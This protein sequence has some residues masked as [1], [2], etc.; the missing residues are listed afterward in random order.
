ME[1][2]RTKIVSEQEV[3]RWFEEGR[4]YQW[5]TD[6]YRRKYNIET[7]VSMWSNFRHR[8]GLPRRIA[9]NDDL[10]P[11]AVSEKH[12]WAYPATMLRLEAR[13]REGMELSDES[14]HRLSLWKQRLD[15]A[16]AVVHYDAETDEGWFYVERRDGI[17]I[18]LIRT[19]GGAARGRRR[20]D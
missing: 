3:R 20:Q 8:R 14:A 16:G 18:D 13:L 19:P 17:D 11:W 2:R 12:R 7:G 15:K 5:M 9:R 6:E 4:T 10:L 1:D